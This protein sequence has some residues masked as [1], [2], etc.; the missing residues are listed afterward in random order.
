MGTIMPITQVRDNIMGVIIGVNSYKLDFATCKEA[1]TFH[2]ELISAYKNQAQNVAV[3]WETGSTC[4]Q[5]CFD[6]EE[7]VSKFE[8][9]FQSSEKAKSF[10]EDLTLLFKQQ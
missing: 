6:T 3:L 8:I 2:R 7:T 10:S 4:V 5:V 9:P 1:E